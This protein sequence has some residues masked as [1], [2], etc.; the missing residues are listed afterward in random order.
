MFKKREIVIMHTDGKET[1]AIML[2]VM[3]NVATITKDVLDDVSDWMRFGKP[4]HLYVL[5]DETLN[6][7]DLYMSKYH[8]IISKYNGTEKLPEGWKKI[9]A[10]TN[11]DLDFPLRLPQL[12]ESFIIY[13]VV[14]Y[15]RGN[16]ITEI[17][18][19]YEEYHGIDTS[20]AEINYVSGDGS[21]GWKGKNDLRDFKLKINLDNTINIKPIKELSKD[22]IDRFFVDMV[23]NPKEEPTHFV[24]CECANALQAENCIRN[25]G[26][27]E[28]PKQ[29]TLEPI[30]YNIG[31]N[32]IIINPTENQPKSFK[33]HK[34]DNNFG[35][36]YYYQ[37]DG[38]EESIGF[39][40]I[41]KE[42]PK[43]ETL[44]EAAEKAYK[45]EAD[46]GF[47]DE[48]E[49]KEFLR[50][51][52]RGAKW[53]QENILQLLKDNDYQDEPVFELL[54]EQFKKK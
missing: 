43:Q 49:H 27:G 11:L 13:F 23:C 7:G 48:H 28:E 10:T 39:S 40:Y 6:K 14:Q 2:G 21:L 37:L 38:K 5:S 24:E 36:V 30:V 54:T 26:H 34:V 42:E 1:S 46:S 41:K 20:I 3:P 52:K 47:P 16:I 25:C 12:R 32:I 15:N 50:I 17:D 19:E 33:T 9:I 22:E 31:D 45:F 18:V 44:E 8:S 51:F 35:V 4:Y 53:Q 29:E